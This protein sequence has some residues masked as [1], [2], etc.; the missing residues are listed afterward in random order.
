MN[1][2]LILSQPKVDQITQ[3]IAYQIH[4]NNIH[5]NVLLLGVDNG[6]RRLAE[7]I[8]KTL[9]EISGKQS[10]T[11]TINLDKDEPLLNDIEIEGHTSDLE[12]KAVI[13]CDDVLNTGRTLSYC[14]AKL[15]GFNVRKIET[16]VL[17]LRSHA[18]FPIFAT[19][20][21]YE[22]STTIKEHV[23]VKAGEGVFLN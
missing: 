11:F 9:R 12:N 10:K 20:K 5:E 16:A 22:L 2:N 15:M 13:L 18:K 8:N 17:I 3:R 21:G 4:E 14:I 19:Y 7:S 23:E 6:G 1:S